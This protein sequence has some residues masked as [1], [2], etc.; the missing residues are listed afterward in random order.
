VVDCV[1]LWQALVPLAVV[2]PAAQV[3][4]PVV[5]CVGRQLAVKIIPAQPQPP[6]L[7]VAFVGDPLPA[8][9]VVLLQGAA[10]AEEFD[11]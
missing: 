1:D 6:L 8:I 11:Q 7:D 9:V 5:D 10:E 4:Q 3:V 2:M